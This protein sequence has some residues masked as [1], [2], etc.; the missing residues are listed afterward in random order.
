MARSS[1]FV[2]MKNRRSNGPALSVAG[3]ERRVC[4]REQLRLWSYGTVSVL[5]ATLLPSLLSATVLA[6][7]ALP[8]KA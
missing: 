5:L 1:E 7:S 4:L 3:F 6:A 2:V 8:M